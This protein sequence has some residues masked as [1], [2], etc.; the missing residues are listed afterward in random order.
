MT[1]QPSD[2][3][4]AKPGTSRLASLTA[5]SLI[6]L[7]LGMLIGLTLLRQQPAW[8][9]PVI[10]VAEALVRAWTN[11]FRVL[12]VPLVIAQLFVALSQGHAG[13]GAVSR[14]G[15]ATPAVFAGLLAM[16]AL[17]STGFTIWAFTLPLLSGLSLPQPDGSRAAE[18]VV[19]SP[20][21]WV[22]GFIPPNL[23]EA[24]AGDGLLPLMIFTL[25]FALASRRVAPALRE[26]LRQGFSAVGAAMLVLVDWLL[27]AT[28]FVVF[29]LGLTS[30]ARAGLKVG[31]ALLAF[32]GLETAALVLALL[33]L[34]PL[35][36]L[37][38]RVRLG[39]FRRA[40][41][42]A[43]WTAVT[44]RSSLATLPA[45]LKTAE[46]AG[47]AVGRYGSYVLPLAGAVLK[48]S[49]AVSSPVKLLFIA[50]LLGIP[51]SPERLLIFT[52]TIILISPST[53]GV[54][55][56]ASGTRSLPAYVAAGVPA[57]YVVLLGATTAVTD[58]FMTLLN[59]TG[60]F[61]ANVL[62]GRFAAPRREEAPEPAPAVP[63]LAPS[64][65]G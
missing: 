21:S 13:K 2:P 39:W 47:G 36:T 22:D 52:V 44:T 4:P 57:E 30:A 54:P 9:A 12:V 32:T 19:T 62:I 43:Q 58:I 60:Y 42:P 26:T 8:G 49:R 10:V 46:E 25:A 17:L 23:F 24:A 28:P 7:L 37:V 6:G 48:L 64:G 55:R 5:R 11:A 63:S 31:G 41:V 1:D 50:Y 45:L 14:L 15:L 61:S 20:T 18:A 51:L 40:V 16:T 59:T 29:A 35:T 56:V 33:M 27:L 65:E 34:Y 3:P 53:P 38:G